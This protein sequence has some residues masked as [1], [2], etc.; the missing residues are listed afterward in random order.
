MTAGRHDVPISPSNPGD[1]SRQVIAKW[2]TNSTLE[3]EFI[4]CL[5]VIQ[6]F[7]NQLCGAIGPTKTRNDAVGGN[8]ESGNET[9]M[10]ESRQNV[11]RLYQ[12]GHCE[13]YEFVYGIGD[14]VTS[15]H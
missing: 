6:Q 12:H 9:S 2:A 14:S 5:L 3:I 1:L 8:P 10:K 13:H 7:N 4:Y 11:I 15:F